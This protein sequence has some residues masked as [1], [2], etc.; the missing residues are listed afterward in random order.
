MT[1]AGRFAARHA[2][3]LGAV[4]LV[5]AIFRPPQPFL[6]ILAAYLLLSRP[7]REI[8][9]RILAAWLA[10]GAGV[11]LVALFPQQPWVLLPVYGGVAI[12]ALRF[13]CRF[14]DEGIVLLVA[15]GLGAGLPAGIGDPARALEAGW[16]HAWNLAIGVC[17]ARFGYFVIPALV[18]PPPTALAEIPWRSAIYIGVA[19]ACAVVAA[20]LV[21][22]GSGVVLVIACLTTGLAIVETPQPH[23][24]QKSIGALAGA[25]IAVAFDSIVS[26]AANSLAVFL[27]AFAFLFGALSWGMKSWPEAAPCLGQC[28]AMFS[29]ASPTVPSPDTSLLPMGIR[30]A[31]VLVGFLVASGIYGLALL[32][33]PVSPEARPDTSG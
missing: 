26:G 29:V 3:T 14:G 28:C 22:P 5:T 7:P 21:L 12:W 9:Q 23:L 15:M 32:A 25:L 20:A 30:V 2:I 4:A 13:S 17:C 19:T 1:E 27:C 10:A 6:A 16:F 11:L 24:I 18:P 33:H 31:A 8:P